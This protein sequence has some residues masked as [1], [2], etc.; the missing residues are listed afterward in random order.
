MQST[1]PFKAFLRKHVTKQLGRQGLRAFSAYR[2]TCPVLL[3]EAKEKDITVQNK[4]KKRGSGG[5]QTAITSPSTFAP[6]LSLLQQDLPSLLTSVNS[7]LNRALDQLNS[8]GHFS[9]M[10]GTSLVDSLVGQFPTPFSAATHLLGA[11]D[12]TQTE[13]EYKIRVD[14]PGVD[15]SDISVDIDSDGCLNISARRTVEEQ[16]EDPSTGTRV[17]EAIDSL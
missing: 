5:F 8:F 7:D 17:Y 16:E 10:P 6:S 2:V 3:K 9:R 14:L 15:A 4:A 11:M 13:D 1:N 12:V